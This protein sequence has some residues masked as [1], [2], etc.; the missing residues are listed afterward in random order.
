MKTNI[1]IEKNSFI[2]GRSILTSTIKILNKTINECTYLEFR[3]FCDFLEGFFLHDKLYIVTDIN[4]ISPDI[5]KFKNLINNHYNKSIINFIDVKSEDL[6]INDRSIDEIIKEINDEILNGRISFVRDQLYSVTELGRRTNDSKDDY[7]NNFTDLL[8]IQKMEINDKHLDFYV[9]TFHNS[10]DDEFKNHLFR[11]VIIAAV[12]IAAKGT[13]K[14]TGTRKTLGGFIIKNYNKY[15]F[16][17]FPHFIYL[18][19]NALYMNYKRNVFFEK[20]LDYYHHLILSIFQSE[21]HRQDVLQTLF[22]VRDKFKNYRN[23]GDYY[24]SEL[25]KKQKKIKT[26]KEKYIIFLDDKAR[27]L[28]KYNLLIFLK[29]FGKELF[30]DTKNIDFI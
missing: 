26:L 17:T 23:N 28:T 27:L 2:S 19:A 12:A 20:T 5:E 18:Y 30:I 7:L 16:S 6:F 3:T 1:T 10:T 25:A 15:S 11:A 8:T 14:F 21:I 22:L 24:Y 13:A 4:N 9:N 29:K